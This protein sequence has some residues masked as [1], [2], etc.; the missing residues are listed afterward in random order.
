MVS[1]RSSGVSVSEILHVGGCEPALLRTVLE[2]A[3]EKGLASAIVA[4][5]R[6]EHALPQA[7]TVELFV[8]GGLETIE[9]DSE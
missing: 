9:A 8:H 6:L 3:R 4:T 2:P 5:D 7:G 1:M